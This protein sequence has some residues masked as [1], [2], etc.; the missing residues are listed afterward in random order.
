[1]TSRRPSARCNEDVDGAEHFDVTSGAQPVFSILSS[2]YRTE[3]Y[4]AETIDSVVAQ[5]L[6]DWE[7]IIVDNGM[8]D[9]V[10][11]IVDKYSDDPR[12]RLIRQENKGLGGGIDAAAAEARGRYYAVLDSDDLLMPEFC[13]RTAA[14]LDANPDVDMVGI[15]AYLFN[16]SDG[17]DQIRSYRQSVGIKTD[18]DVAHRVSL[19][20][21][22]RGDVIYYTAAIRASAWKVGGG[23]SC[24]TPKVE[25]L[26]MFMR[27]LAAGSDIRVMNERL[28]RYRLRENSFSR[29]P[30]HQDAFEESL[31]RAFIQATALTDAPEV[32]EALDVTLRRIRFN[33]AIRRSRSA[34]LAGDT[35][36]AR[37]QAKRAFG[38]K[39]SLRPA[40]VVVGL[41]VAPGV[42][43]QIHPLKQKI[44]HIA[45]S[46]AR[47]QRKLLKS[48]A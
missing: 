35:T 45:A 18:A 39:R 30:Q 22:I 31:E 44:S 25:D 14:V 12:I 28:A 2:A 17:Q 48:A 11:R 4:L 20:E 23:Y 43:R 3:P 36:T 37:E 10:V 24:D 8:S 9:E 21:V 15:D 42:L 40:V 38:Q 26:A 5:T 47:R 46:I 6:L 32:Q 41:T 13:A 7:L 27:M 33:Q 34:L 1:M 19:A 16:D 29:D